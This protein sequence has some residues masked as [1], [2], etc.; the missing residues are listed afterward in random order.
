MLLTLVMADQLL[1]ARRRVVLGRG[2]ALWVLFLVFVVLGAFVLWVQAPATEAG[3]G[4]QRLLVWAYRLA[5]YLAATTTLLWVAN[6]RESELPTRWVY[7]LLGVMFVWTTVG[8]LAGVLAPGIDF[9]SPLELLMPGGL[10]SNSLVQSIVHPAVADIQTVLGRPE[11]RP[12]APFAFANSWGSAM[13]LF[14]P[15]FL[16]AWFRDGRTWQRVLGPIVLVASAVPIIYSLNRGLWIC[17]VIGAAGFVVL[18]LRQGRPWQILVTIGLLVAAAVVFLFSPLSTVLDERLAN[19]HSN[20]RRSQ[21]LEQT[22]VS[23]WQGSPVVG[24]GSTRDLQGGFASIASGATPDCPA[25]AVP[26]LGTQGHLWLVIFSQGFVGAFLFLGFF[27]IALWQ[28]WRCRTTNEI[29]CTFVLVFLGMQLLIYDTLGIPLMTVMIA[30]G[31]VTREQATHRLRNADQLVRIAWRRLRGAWPVVTIA[32]GLGA[33]IGGVVIA[34]TPPVY[35]TKASILLTNPPVYLATGG[36]AGD[37]EAQ[38][39]D[40]ETVTIDTEAVLLLSEQS[41]SRTED[42][43]SLRDRVS[44]TAPANTRVMVVEVRDEDPW[45]S[46]RDADE[47]AESYL[48]TRENFLAERRDLTLRQLRSRIDELGQEGTEADG[49]LESAAQARASLEQAV[50]SVLLTPTTAGEVIRFSDTTVVRRQWELPVVTGAALGV[51]AVAVG[52]SASRRWPWGRPG[53]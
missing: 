36:G 15:F 25:C 12:K 26:P 30:I 39:V 14:L 2:T 28:C 3:G 17:L 49:G 51:I 48:L 32:V 35:S 38:V 52:M 37:G 20:D 10:R 50:T 24:F 9:N 21:L 27:A 19:Q 8:G 1:R 5:W 43:E 34:L 16:V 33:I 7:Q 42:G 44:V 6:L 4:P 53:V 11:A 46:A 45:Q 18:Q 31:L 22:V 40:S 23:T 13:A 47:L 41:L 29:L